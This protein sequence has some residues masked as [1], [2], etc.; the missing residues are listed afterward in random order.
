MMTITDAERAKIQ[1][2]RAALQETRRATVPAL[3]E[4]LFEAFQVLDHG[5]IRVIDY[6]AAQAR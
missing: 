3:E 5:F 1:T 2:A 4:I 6:K